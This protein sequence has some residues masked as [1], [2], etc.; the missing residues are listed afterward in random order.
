MSD[1]LPAGNAIYQEI[2]NGMCI[3]GISYS[4]DD[5]NQSAQIVA[6]I[7]FDSL[8]KK[9][10]EDYLLSLSDTGFRKINAVYPT[11][12]DW[13]VGEG[14]AE[15]YLTAHFS[16]FFPWSNN[17]DLKNPNSSLTGADLVG[18]HQGQFAFGEVKTS[19]ELKY[20]P[21]VTSKKDD[22]LNT[23]LKKLCHNHDIRWVLI[24]YLFHRMKG[25]TEYREA[26]ISYLKDNKNFY[27][28]GALVRNV[29]PNINDWNYLKKHLEVHEQNRVSL[30]A[31][32]LPQNDGIQKLHACVLSKGAKS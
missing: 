13:Q 8:G 1:T 9:D 12:R 15:A 24:Q 28:F 11:I 30:V 14:F 7:C 20:P 26:C 23:Q 19:T 25:K 27:V 29:E 18:F 10:F 21:Q 2:H 6:D 5:L 4:E 16:C 32:Y 17:R 22:G 31:L 3:Q